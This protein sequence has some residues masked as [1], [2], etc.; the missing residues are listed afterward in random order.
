MFLYCFFLSVMFLL[1]HP[2]YPPCH[3][4]V[5][6]SADGPCVDLDVPKFRLTRQSAGWR[7]QGAPLYRCPA[8][9][10]TSLIPSTRR[11]G[12]FLSPSLPL[13]QFMQKGGKWLS[14]KVLRENIIQVETKISVLLELLAMIAFLYKLRKK[15]MVQADHCIIENWH[16]QVVTILRSLSLKQTA[17]TKWKKLRELE[18]HEEARKKNGRWAASR[19][20]FFALQQQHFCSRPVRVWKCLVL[21]S[22]EYRR[23]KN[24][25]A[26]TQA[27]VEIEED[28]QQFVNRDTERIHCQ[29]SEHFVLPE[30]GSFYFFFLK[31]L[32]ED[33]TFPLQIKHEDKNLTSIPENRVKKFLTNFSTYE[34]P[35]YD[36]WLFLLNFPQIRKD[37]IC[38]KKFFRKVLLLLEADGMVLVRN[39][40]NRRLRQI[41]R[42][43]DING[44]LAYMF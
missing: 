44:R 8:V 33:E 43:P 14:F 21:L 18:A 7:Q 16:F 30:R 3:A 2:V 19:S 35:T 10:S 23:E 11:E 38:R 5:A 24:P 40:G 28:A 6:P 25:T 31:V 39:G 15:S 34:R 32:F 1:T 20:S 26:V 13:C 41:R 37:V 17:H 27:Q 12:L 29:Q 42:A 9:A 22:A 36:P 4:T